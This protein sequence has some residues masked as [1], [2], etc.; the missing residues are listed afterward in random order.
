MVFVSLYE[1]WIRSLDN[2]HP[3]VFAA[4]N[5][6]LGDQSARLIALR[7]PVAGHVKLCVFSSTVWHE[8]RASHAQLSFAHQDFLRPANCEIDITTML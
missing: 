7:G 6:S 8:S 2:W 3:L 5:V 4:I 1:F